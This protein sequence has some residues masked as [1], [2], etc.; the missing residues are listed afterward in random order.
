MLHTTFRRFAV[1]R[2]APELPRLATVVALL[3]GA[4]AALGIL[5][6]GQY[7]DVDWIRATWF[8]ND[9]VTLVVAAP[10][11]VGGTRFV[12]RGSSCGYVVMLGVLAYAIYNYSF[13]LFG[14]ALISSPHSISC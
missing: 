1:R 5:F 10:L 6:R 9:W 12:R 11:L 14:A 2:A 4:Q 8:G 3:M 13:Y 7:R